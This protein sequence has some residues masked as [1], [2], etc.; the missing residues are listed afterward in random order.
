MSKFY[1]EKPSLKRKEE[2]IDYINEHFEFNSDIHGT[3]SLQKWIDNYEGW[4]EQLELRDNL[5]TCPE[6]LVP[7]S[8]YFLIREDEDRIVGMIDIRHD[9]NDYLLQYGGHIGYG[10]R[11][12]E[13]RNGY[14]KINL[15]LGLLKCRE[16]GFDKVLITAADE[17]PGSYKTILDLGGKLE[18][19]IIDDEDDNVLLGR[20]WIDV[21]K[22]INDNY[23]VYKESIVL[24]DEIRN[25]FK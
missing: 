11:P 5:D 9:L 13:R 6:S 12:T 23:E 19:K 7:S 10:I 25:K 20:Y 16:L 18:N 17:N 15:F 24:D 21:D 8:T 1:L 3:G 2:A 22:S 14:N 4:L